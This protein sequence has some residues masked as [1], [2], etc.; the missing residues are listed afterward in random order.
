MNFIHREETGRLIDLKA[1][2][3]V[4]QK[5]TALRTRANGTDQVVLERSS[6][7]ELAA[8]LLWRGTG[9]VIAAGRRR[10]VGASGVNTRVVLYISP[11][12]FVVR[13]CNKT[14]DH[15]RKEQLARRGQYGP[16]Q[17]RPKR[18]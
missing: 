2:V 3:V 10:M 16:R 14:N 8:A 12:T 7:A 13:V 6:V 4:G 9:D 17:V 15:L 11:L 1:N 5:E 18:G